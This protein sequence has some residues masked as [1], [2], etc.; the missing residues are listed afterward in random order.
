M[1][2]SEQR[3]LKLLLAV[4]DFYP[5]KLLELFL[6]QRCIK[7]TCSHCLHHSGHCFIQEAFA[8]CQVDDV[9][10]SQNR[11][12]GSVVFWM[13]GP[14][15]LSECVQ[16]I[17][18]R[19]LFGRLDLQDVTRNQQYGHV[20]HRLTHISVALGPQLVFILSASHGSV[21]HHVLNHG[22]KRLTSSCTTKIFGFHVR[23]QCSRIVA[24]AIVVCL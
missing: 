8:L 23:S 10:N 12:L 14:T 5:A 2:V 16:V 1:P 19:N 17:C 7:A 20:P 11:I 4:L 21:K 22:R 6:L 13:Y 15:G 9:S 3:C 18:Y 24:K